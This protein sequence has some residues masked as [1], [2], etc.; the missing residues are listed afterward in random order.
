[1]NLRTDLKDRYPVSFIPP[2]LSTVEVQ[3]EEQQKGRKADSIRTSSK[4]YRPYQ[5]KLTCVSSPLPYPYQQSVL[6]SSALQREISSGTTTEVTAFLAYRHVTSRDGQ[7]WGE[8]SHWEMG[9]GRRRPCR[10]L[11]LND[12]QIT[13]SDQV[14]IGRRTIQR[15]EYVAPLVS[16][17][18]TKPSTIETELRSRR[19]KS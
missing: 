3:G 17:S 16:C 4:L 1:M 9:R 7:S 19:H 8:I 13:S 15:L 18:A 11:M 6:R 10:R 2:S 14:T 5:A 12:A